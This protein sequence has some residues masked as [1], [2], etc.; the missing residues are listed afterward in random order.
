MSNR[1][2][3][4]RRAGL[5]ALLAT[6]ATILA[7]LAPAQALG[8]AAELVAEHRAAVAVTARYDTGTP[9]AEAQITVFAPDDPASPWLQGLTDGDGRFVFV[10]DD[11]AGRWSVRVRQAGHGAIVHLDLDGPAA[12]ASATPVLATAGAGPTTPQKL[13][14]AASLVWGCIGTALYFR[15]RGAGHA[16]S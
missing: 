1:S 5:A 9:M 2:R 10:P 13:I 4:M 16:P 6:A 11:Q 7:A 3:P 15:R 14:M 12:T 8:H